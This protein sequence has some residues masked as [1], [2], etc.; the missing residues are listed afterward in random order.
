M[1]AKELIALLSTLPPDSRIRYH[2]WMCSRYPIDIEEVFEHD[3][4]FV[5]S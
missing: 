2:N 3:D 1:N 5:L 4:G